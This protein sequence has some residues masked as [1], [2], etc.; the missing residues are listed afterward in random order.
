MSSHFHLP[1]R[2]YDDK[3]IQTEQVINPALRNKESPQQPSL[4]VSL[5]GVVETA[6][7]ERAIS[8]ESAYIPSNLPDPSSS[9]FL[10]NKAWLGFNYPSESLNVAQRRVVSVPDSSR[11]K[12][13]LE[14]NIR[15]VSMPDS[16]RHKESL[17]DDADDQAVEEIGS[18]LFGPG[19]YPGGL[20][21]TPTPPSSPDSFLISENES[22]IHGSIFTNADKNGMSHLKKTRLSEC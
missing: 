22:R 18:R 1:T 3:A 17:V 2:Y 15:I 5:S 16:F 4:A 20:P 6:L 12:T 13:V 21:Q 19:E 10:E 8:S 9:T 7:G 14:R 11:V